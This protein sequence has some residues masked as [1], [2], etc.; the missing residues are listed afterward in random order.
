VFFVKKSD[1]V[2]Q[3]LGEKLLTPPRSEIGSAFAPANIALCKYWGKRDEELNLPMSSSLS[4]SLAKKGAAVVIQLADH[5]EVFLN[6]NAVNT[7]S[8][9]SQRLFQF[10]NLFR[11]QQKINFYI[12][13]TSNIP[14]AAGLASS[15]SGFASITSALA[16]LMEWNCSTKELSILAR[17]GSGSASRSLWQGFVEWQAGT[18]SDGMDSF[19]IPLDYTWPDFCIGLLVLDE[20]QKKISSRAAMRQTVKTSPLYADWPQ[21]VEQDLLIT[22]NAIAEK[23]FTQLGETAE[24]NALAMHATM[25]HAVPPINYSSAET[26]VAMQKVWDLR[27]EGLEVYFTQDA[28]PNL[29]LLCLAKNAPQLRDAFPELEIVQPFQIKANTPLFSG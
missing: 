19:G 5:D 20:Q 13:I 3:I 21:R 17:L 14:I 18:R 7:S 8:G 1:V 10:I 12:T 27:A 29:K 11:E 24:T 22:K 28:G 9:F 26:T 15:A 25:R 6:G 23:N 2:R 16:D 4:I